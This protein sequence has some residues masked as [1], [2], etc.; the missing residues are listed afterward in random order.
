MRGEGASGGV[1]HSIGWLLGRQDQIKSSRSAA[2]DQG[3]NGRAGRV[4]RAL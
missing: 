2:P 1:D 4:A 3:M